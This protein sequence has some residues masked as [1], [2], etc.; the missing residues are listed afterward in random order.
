M[1]YW[2]KDNVHEIKYHINKIFKF[3]LSLKIHTIILEK[4]YEHNEA[5]NSSQPKFTNCKSIFW[6]IESVYSRI[7]ML[8]YGVYYHEPYVPSGHLI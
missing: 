8:F 2:L 7:I 3:L 1:I 4:N 5:D 6:F